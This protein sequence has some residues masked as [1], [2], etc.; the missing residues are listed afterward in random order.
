VEII[1]IV[2]PEVKFK[3]VCTKGT[4]IRSIVRDFGQKLNSGAYLNSLIRTKIGEYS[5]ENSMT[6]ENFEVNNHEII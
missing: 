1:E 3:I 6:M 4:Y 2:I 5:I